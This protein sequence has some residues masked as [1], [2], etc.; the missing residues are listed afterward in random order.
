MPLDDIHA[1]VVHQDIQPPER[2]A[3]VVA[4]LAHLVLLGQV[5]GLHMRGAGL[6]DAARDILQRAGAAAGQDDRRTFLGQRQC[7]GLANAGA[8]AGD[9]G[10][11]PR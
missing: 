8:R 7:G 4:D 3:D 1:G 9:P 2:I 5:G 11:L 10:D 6:V